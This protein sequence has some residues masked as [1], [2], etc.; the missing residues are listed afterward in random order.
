MTHKRKVKSMGKRTSR[1]KQ[2]P[3]EPQQI[4]IPI[5]QCNINV[6][7]IDQ[8]WLLVGVSSE[9]GMSTSGHTWDYAQVKEFVDGVTP[10]L[11]ADRPVKDDTPATELAVVEGLVGADGQPLTS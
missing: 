6:R 8:E 11:E 1:Q 9:N 10:W 4:E 7:V 3:Q 2:T 5:R